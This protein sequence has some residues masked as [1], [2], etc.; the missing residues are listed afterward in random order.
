VLVV[1]FRVSA[2]PGAIARAASALGVAPA[3]MQVKLRGIL[4]RVVVAANDEARAVAAVAT[5]EEL[6]FAA[7]ACDPAAAPDD[8]ERVVARKVQLEGQR[9]VVWDGGG[10]QHLL[11]GGALALV[12]R[13]VR[14]HT[15]IKTVTTSERRFAPVRAVLSSGLLL[16]K[17][18]KKTE[19]QTRDAREPFLML[20][21]RDGAPDLILY[22]RRID[23][24]LLGAAMQPSSAANLRLVEERVRALAPGAAFDDRASRPGFVSSLPATSADPVD[25]ALFLLVLGHARGWAAAG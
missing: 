23:Y 21:R 7:A 6:G 19:V 4:P 18:T 8:A 20:H 2:A 15:T 12:I 5:L 14:T 10:E 9:L 13:G 24:R 3:E 17:T 25:L 1:V 11:P 16:T 22:E